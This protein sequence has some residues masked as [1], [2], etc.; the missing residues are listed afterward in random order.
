MM[1]FWTLVRRSLRFHARAHLGVLLG[2]TIGSATLIGSLLVGD[3]VR[4]RLREMGLK[5]LGK[6]HFPLVSHDR[7]FLSDIGERLGT[8]P[9]SGYA[10][11]GKRCS[12]LLLRGTVARQDG[13]ARA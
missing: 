9:S 1:T 7:F 11:L 2:A 13:K 4:E 6:T 8:D 12:A 3:S 5:R 10:R